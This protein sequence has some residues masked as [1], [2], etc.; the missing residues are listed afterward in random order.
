MAIFFSLMIIFIVHVKDIGVS[1]LESDLP[2]PA[3]LDRP[4]SFTISFELV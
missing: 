4:G 3:D 1:N 2:F